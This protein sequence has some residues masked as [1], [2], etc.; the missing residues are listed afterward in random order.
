MF[1]L[2]LALAVL[3]GFFGC[4]DDS[5]IG[6]IDGALDGDDEPRPDGDAEA[7]EEANEGETEDDADE[8]DGDEEVAPLAAEAGFM[9]IEPVTFRFVKGRYE[10]SFTSTPARLWYAFQPAEENPDDKPLAIFFNG[11]PG[12]STGI[13]FGFNTAARTLDPAF[14]GDDAVTASPAPWTRLANLL[15]VDARQTGFSYSLLDDV[16]DADA[17]NAAFGADNHNCFFDA[18]DF[19]RLLLRFLQAHPALTDNP[20][21]IVG[22]SYGGL[23]ATV[24][25]HLLLFASRY[26]DGAAVYQD[27]T[28]VEEI[29]AHYGAVFPEHAGEL[30]PPELAAT[31]F[32]RQVLVQP[33]L[34]GLYQD[35][36]AGRL[37]DMDGS[38]MFRMAEEED[39]TFVPC[40]EQGEDCSPYDNGMGFADTVAER[41]L[42]NWSKPKGWMDAVIA[43][44]AAKLLLVGPL[45]EAL[46]ADARG[47]EWLYAA[48]R[49]QAFRVVGDEEEKKLLSAASLARLPFVE[50][51][52]LM[53]KPRFR[54]A[55]EGDLPDV[56]GALQTWDRYY[57]SINEL[58]TITFYVNG[59]MAFEIDPFHPR[60]GE[61]F[62][63][64]LLYVN[65]FIT[66]AAFDL[67]IYAPALPPALERH[68]DL[69]EQV[70]H[71][72]APREGE[73]RGG[74][75]TVRYKPDAFGQ[76]AA[77]S[78][79]V[80]FPLYPDSCHAVEI[81]EPVEFLDDVTAWTEDA[82]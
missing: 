1:M 65:T 10:K 13:L 38:P 62:L 16:A 17:R 25:L 72:T 37:W 8:T 45:S 24:M 23:R 63:E 77:E 35:E 19:V 71:E 46:G 66:H 32:A 21:W 53:R 60:Y 54:A 48:E 67:V 79:A 52:R 74:W 70:E 22:E 20:V 43:D 59:A 5:D 76:T 58:V 36:E 28:L 47:V 69:V 2:L 61:L 11:G 31:Q 51:W 14:T 26:A 4:A 39:E 56:F 41:D 81:T 6:L 68:D 82:D 75:M 73:A 9:E 57:L 55:A 42:Y 80:R 29:K 18:A 30:P 44:G 34:T 64:D 12:S 40:R 3:A 50:R 15:Y 49:A 78:R 33:L 7:D 27:P